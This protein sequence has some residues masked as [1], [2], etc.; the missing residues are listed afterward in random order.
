MLDN[1]YAILIGALAILI[2]YRIG[3]DLVAQIKKNFGRRRKLEDWCR[4]RQF[5]LGG[6]GTVISAGSNDST[7]STREIGEVDQGM[8]AKYPEFTVFG[9]GDPPRYAFNIWRG[10][11]KGRD[12][13][14]FDYRYWTTGPDR[15]QYSFSALIV[16]GQK[17]LKPLEVSPRE[18]REDEAEPPGLGEFEQK[19]HVECGDIAWSKKILT[20]A[21]QDLLQT[22]P[23]SEI[24][25]AH[26]NKILIKTMDP[27]CDMEELDKMLDIAHGILDA[28]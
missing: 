13:L 6:K 9:S 24:F 28:A 11:S 21:V 18:W 3:G 2:F 10:K 16:T 12:V 7:V 15:G 17:N 23:C 20:Q 1:W 8:A 27:V 5:Q 26:G 22:D 25:T 19:W 14:G 4:L